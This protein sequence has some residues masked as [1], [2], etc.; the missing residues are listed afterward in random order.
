MSKEVAFVKY[1]ET[2]TEKK[3]IDRV[4]VT[5]GFSWGAFFLSAIWIGIKAKSWKL[6]W[7]V[8]AANVFG[9]VLAGALLGEAA[10]LGQLFIC[11]AWAFGAYEIISG[12]LKSQGYAK[13]E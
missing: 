1:V 4:V 10:I 12:E 7:I 11:A 6:F 8:A 13:E 3:V 5:E 9:S 2:A